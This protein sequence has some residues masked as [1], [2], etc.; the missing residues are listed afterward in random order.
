MVYTIYAVAHD[1]M[2]YRSRQ[3]YCINRRSSNSDTVG[4]L[5]NGELVYQKVEQWIL[6]DPLTLWQALYDG[7][8][9]LSLTYAAYLYL[10]KRMNLLHPDK[11][12]EIEVK[13]SNYA[14]LRQLKRNNPYVLLMDPHAR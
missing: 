6:N 7:V 14:K 8:H 10:K 5:V 2:A 11:V 4:I 1:I 12:K 13:R 3:L 9:K